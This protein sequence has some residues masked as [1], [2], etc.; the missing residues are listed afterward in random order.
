MS[1]QPSQSR[2]P[3]PDTA[4]LAKAARHVANL[5]DVQLQ[6]KRE[7]DRE[8]QRISRAR[9]R[10]RVKV[11]EDENAELKSRIAALEV[12][13]TS[14]LG[15]AAPSGPLP[16]TPPTSLPDHGAAAS[17]TKIW[18]VLPVSSEPTCQPDAKVDWVVK[19]HLQLTSYEE[20][21]EEMRRLDFPSVGSLLNPE[22]DKRTPLSTLIG[23]HSQTMTIASMAARTAWQ[24]SPTEE[25]YMAMPEFYRPLPIQLIKP[26]PRWVDFIIW[27]A[28]REQV[29]KQMDCATQQSVFFEAHAATLN[30]NWPGEVADILTTSDSGEVV[31]NPDFVA[32]INK[33]ENWTVGRELVE[34]LPFL[35]GHVPLT[36]TQ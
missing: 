31:F 7:N 10:E 25:N 35:K 32:H 27:P 21:W 14:H 15:S 36:P 29:I 1:S 34:R 6:K 3:P 5:S 20:L 4:T 2:S 12:A 19:G 16:P 17:H 30:C 8:N 23:R 22:D 11:L 24:I 9:K 18:R 33:I 28:V 13:V 26:H